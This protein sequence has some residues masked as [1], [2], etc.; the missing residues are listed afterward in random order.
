MGKGAPK[1]NEMD[2]LVID[3]PVALQPSAGSFYAG[4]NTLHMPKDAA[5]A[6]LKHA[7]SGVGAWLELVAINA[8][9]GG[10]AVGATN[11]SAEAGGFATGL[12]AKATVQGGLAHAS[13]V[14]AGGVAGDAQAERVM[15]RGIVSAAGAQVGLLRGGTTGTVSVPA[16]AGKG[17]SVR[18]RAYA[19][20]TGGGTGVTVERTTSFDSAGNMEGET[21]EVITGTAANADA[22][23]D[24]LHVTIAAGVFVV[25]YKSGAVSPAQRIACELEIITLDAA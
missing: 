25:N 24:A 7:V 22:V 8:S 23:G 12:F 4:K 18:A 15:V 16:P 21:A 6:F 3:T 19:V 14:F 11:S 5:R 1:R 2:L 20:A 10:A 13:G 17:Y 9:T